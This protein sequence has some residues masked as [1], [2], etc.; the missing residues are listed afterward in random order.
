MSMVTDG[1][2]ALE[3]ADTAGPTETADDAA[4]RASN[5]RAIFEILSYIHA[6]A[7]KDNYSELADRIEFALNLAERT[8]K[9]SASAPASPTPPPAGQPT[10]PAAAQIPDQIVTQ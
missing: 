1:M 5:L 2:A 10:A 4:E 9:N 3:A 8:I 6:D 7:V